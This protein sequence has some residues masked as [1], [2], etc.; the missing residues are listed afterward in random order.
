MAQTCGVPADDELVSGRQVTRREIRREVQIG[1][2]GSGRIAQGELAAPHRPRFAQ[3]VDKCVHRRDRGRAL[4]DPECQRAARHPLPV[5]GDVQRRFPGAFEQNA[6]EEST[7]QL[8]HPI[9]LAAGGDE[10]RQVETARRSDT[11][12]NERIARRQLRA[13]RRRL[14]RQQELR[15]ARE[16]CVR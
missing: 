15:G 2:A 11:H 7:A 13:A 4:R 16:C 12:V 14:A 5:G 1:E 6:G 3:R 9:G 10:R 8:E